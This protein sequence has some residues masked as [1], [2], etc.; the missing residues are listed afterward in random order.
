MDNKSVKRLK[1]MHGSGNGANP[2]KLYF[3][4]WGAF[5]LLYIVGIALPLGVTPH[6]YNRMSRIWNWTEVLILSPS[7]AP[8]TLSAARRPPDSFPQFHGYLHHR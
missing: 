2:G 4:F 8:S 7:A 6:Y 5:A 1:Q 3:A